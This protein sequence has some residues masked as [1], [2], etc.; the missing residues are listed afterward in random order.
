[1]LPCGAKIYLSYGGTTVLT[2]VIDRGPSAAGRELEVTAPVAAK[3]GLRGV[4]R[5]RWAYASR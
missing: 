2:Q 1:V 4:E 3:L 5:I